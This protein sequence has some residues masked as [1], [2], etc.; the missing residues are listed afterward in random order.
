MVTIAPRPD[1]GAVVAMVTICATG[2]VSGESCDAFDGTSLEFRLVQPATRGAGGIWSVDSVNSEP[3]A[4]SM[5]ATLDEPITAGGLFKFGVGDIPQ[6][7]TAHLGI[8]ASNGCNV[9]HEEDELTESG[10][11][12]LH[13]PNVNPASPECEAPPGGYAFAYVTRDTAPPT[14]DPL[15]V[16]T[17]IESPWLSIVPFSLD[18]DLTK[19]VTSTP[20]PDVNAQS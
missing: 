20:Q 4:I 12:T 13:V 1:D 9:L 8:V 7:T 5:Y 10:Q 15:E 16:S 18:P 3:L 19:T 14:Y 11:V 17:A 2:A 6:G